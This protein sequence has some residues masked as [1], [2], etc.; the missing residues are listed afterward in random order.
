MSDDLTTR[1][2][3]LAHLGSSGA[4][5]PASS[6]R[7]RGERARRNRRVA[8]AVGTSLV[9]AAIVVPVVVLASSSSGRGLKPSRLPI[10]T[11]PTTTGPSTT[12]TTPPHPV[13]TTT[14]PTKSA[15]PAPIITSPPTTSSPSA[16]SPPTPTALPGAP[17]CEEDTAGANGPDTRPTLIFI[18]CATSADYLSSITWTTWSSTSAIGSATHAI[19]DCQPS[20]ATGAYTTFPVAVQL[21]NP[22][23]LDGMFVF[24]TISMTPTTSVGHAE[25]ETANSPY[26]SWGWVPN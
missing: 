26:G 7:R 5:P 24:E 23:Y 15:A 21:S 16:T 17:P 18:G 1:L 22:G 20:C 14:V 8:V 19:N 13:T 2:K 6:I 3:R 11:V 25:T 10:A 12:T 4:L 9:A